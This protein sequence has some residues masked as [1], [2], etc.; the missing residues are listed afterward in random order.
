[1]HGSMFEADRAF[2]CLLSKEVCLMVNDR[3]LTKGCKRL[4]VIKF[5]ASFVTKIKSNP[6][7]KERKESLTDADFSARVARFATTI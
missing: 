1:M 4:S 2:Q 3:S 7:S 6:K 5:I